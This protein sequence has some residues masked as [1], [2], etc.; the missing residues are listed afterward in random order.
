MIARIVSHAL[1]AGLLIGCASQ[2]PTPAPVTDR[3]QTAQAAR[4]AD[5]EI[6]EV[7][8]GDTLY[9]IAW[10]SGIDFRELAAWNGIES[11]Y[12]IR[13]G[14][15]LRLKPPP[16]PEPESR[17]KEERSESERSATAEKQE[18]PVK[19]ATGVVRKP[20]PRIH[21][22]ARGETLNSIARH[23]KIDARKLAAWNNLS[24]PYRLSPG[25]KLRLGPAQSEPSPEKTRPDR[26]SPKSA[27]A[28]PGSEKPAAAK[29]PAAVSGGW[30]WP[31]K[32]TLLERYKPNAAMKGIDIG[33][34]KGQA[35]HAASG[36][37]VVYQGSGLRGYGQLIIIKHDA[38]Y[39]SAYAHCDRIY[40]KEG[41]MVKRGQKIAD[42]GASGTDRVKLHFEIRYR[43]A[44]VDPLAHLP[45]K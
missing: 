30:A 35:V 37:R 39:L 18:R 28:R 13:P 20:A 38:D 1:L 29:S 4:P 16:G 40:V 44:P 2:R 31:A 23:K 15:N 7:K 33:G 27:V 14:Q 12:T 25:Q 24:P 3:T 22:V 21:V 17:K 36:G 5:R 34:K 26:E 41:D 10:E 45:K 19:T 11:P 32:G 43:G 9:S 6:R 8:T 42:M